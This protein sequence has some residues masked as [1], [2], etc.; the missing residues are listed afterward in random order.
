MYFIFPKL[1][2][3]NANDPYSEI[4]EWKKNP[5][6]V[7]SHKLLFRRA[8]ESATYMTKIID[9]VWST[10][11]T[12]PKIHIAYAISVCEF[13]LD[14]NNQKIQISEHFIKPKIAKYLQRILNKKKLSSDDDGDDGDDDVD[15][16]AAEV[17]AESSK[18]GE[19]VI[20]IDDEEKRSDDGGCEDDHSSTSEGEV[21]RKSLIQKYKK[22]C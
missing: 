3:I 11:K 2:T 22:K 19:V 4:S 6:V 20:E 14:P 8:D 9:K 10:K 7:E 21:L 15:N 12:T 5:V 13:M 18:E 17:E 16:G 1:P